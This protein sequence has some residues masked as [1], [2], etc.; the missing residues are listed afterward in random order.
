VLRDSRATTS[1][2]S[3]VMKRISSTIRSGGVEIVDE[4][5]KEA[6]LKTHQQVV[7]QLLGEIVN[8]L[9]ATRLERQ[10]YNRHF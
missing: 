1:V 6:N 9:K 10:Q 3:V 8:E 4:G 5:A 2:S 7:E